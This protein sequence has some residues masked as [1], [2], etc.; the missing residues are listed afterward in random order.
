MTLGAG[1]GVAFTW[2]SNFSASTGLITWFCIGVTYLRFYQG[3]KV[4]GID[5]RTLPFAP[6]VQPFAG[7]WSVLG[8]G[9]LLVVRVFGSY[10]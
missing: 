10:N 4:Q 1:S 9:L 3:M 5:R 6:R 7:W 2:L 8:T